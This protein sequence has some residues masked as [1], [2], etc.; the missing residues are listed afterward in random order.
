MNQPNPTTPEPFRRDAEGRLLASLTD[1]KVRMHDVVTRASIAE[2][3][4]HLERHGKIVAVLIHP[5]ELRI[6]D[7]IE[8]K[9]VAKGAARARKEP[10]GR[11]Y[12]TAEVLADGERAAASREAAA[13]KGKPKG[14]KRRSA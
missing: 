14:R 7:E 11:T 10:R 5:E 4:V 1:L 12:T 3:R 6:L 2:E 9:F 8:D 13:P